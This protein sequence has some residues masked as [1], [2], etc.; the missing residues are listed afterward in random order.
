MCAYKYNFQGS[1]K[2]FYGLFVANLETIW[3]CR[4]DAGSRSWQV[5]AKAEPPSGNYLQQIASLS[6][7]SIVFGLI[8]LK[9]SKTRQRHLLDPS[10][11]EWIDT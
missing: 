6:A 9:S 7:A 11:G 10:C 8:L 3:E 4:R 5:Q 1:I 2:A